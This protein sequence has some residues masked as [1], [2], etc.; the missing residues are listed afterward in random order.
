[1]VQTKIVHNTK[2]HQFQKYKKCVTIGASYSNSYF[3]GIVRKQ[4]PA[5]QATPYFLHFFNGISTLLFCNNVE[6]EKYSIHVKR[7][8]LSLNEF[9]FA[10]AIATCNG[11]TLQFR[12]MFL[13]TDTIL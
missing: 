12:P 8:A 11:A 13:S 1:M 6:N 10:E 4:M 3:K 5:H 7:R 2:I 9:Q